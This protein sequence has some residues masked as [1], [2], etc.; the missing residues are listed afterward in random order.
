MT[1]DSK[2]FRWGIIGCGL[3]APRFFQALE[4]TGD[5][6]VVAAA[7]KSLR[8]AK[9]FRKMTGVERIYDSY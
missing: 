4:N 7:S 8:R 9:R 5:G 1:N 6:R 3:I 2:P